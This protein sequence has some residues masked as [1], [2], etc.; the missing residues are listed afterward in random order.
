MSERREILLV[1]VPAGLIPPDGFPKFRE[2]V[3][4]SILRDVLV[5]SD[6]MEMQIRELPAKEE[7]KIMVKTEIDEP[8]S[9]EPAPVP[10]VGPKNA[11]EEKQDILERLKAYR[12]KHG[13]GSLNLVADLV[14]RKGA[15]GDILRMLLQGDAKLDIADWRAV[16]KALDQLEGGADG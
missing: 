1:T 15:T 3:I 12:E 6:D 2:Y 14:R 4:E 10:K 13:L 7:P 5:L 16:G 11:R 8:G 9:P